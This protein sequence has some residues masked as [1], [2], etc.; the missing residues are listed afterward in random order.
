[1]KIT[2]KVITKTSHYLLGHSMPN[3]QMGYTKCFVF[4]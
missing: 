2:Q 3:E 1:M 4:K